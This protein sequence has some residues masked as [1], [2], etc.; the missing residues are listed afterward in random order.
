MST[1]FYP[2][3]MSTYNNRL[4]QG[5]YK[6][7]KGTGP[8]SNPTGIT[9][10][11]IRPLTNNDIGN[12]FTTGFGLPRPI[13]HYRKGIVIPVEKISNPTNNLE[14]SRINDNLNRNVKS[15]YGASLGGGAGGRGLTTQI[16]DAPGSFLVK[17]NPLNETNQSIQS[18]IDCS[19]CKGVSLVANYYPNTTYLTDNPETNTTNP[20]LCCNPERKA[21]RR[22]LPAS[23]NLKKNYYTTLQQYRQNRCQ[24]YEQRVFNF[25]AGLNPELYNDLNNTNE[26][27]TELAIKN[28]KPGSP[29]ALLNTYVANC[30]PNAEL[31]EASEINLI[32]ALVIL[33]VQNGIISAEQAQQIKDLK[34]QTFKEITDYISSL[35]EPQKTA[36]I[37]FYNYFISNPYSGVP[38]TGPS[39]PNGC[40]LVVYK[41]N[42][43][44]F[45]VQGAVSSST[46]ILKL[47]VDTI[48]TNYASF[49]KETKINKLNPGSLPIAPF[50]YKFKV[51][52]CNPGNLIHFQNHKSCSQGQA[53][54][55]QSP[56]PTNHFTQNFSAM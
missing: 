9:S 56:F 26:F 46:R 3:G 30:Q 21:I 25:K 28:A 5:G 43:P 33:M 53:E 37:Q 6:T 29:L 2:L 22:V 15:S 40:K 41:P 1:A 27:I 20:P 12:V 23:T 31:E 10:S 42:N 18:D 19:T 36:A 44:Q 14:I 13:K 50:L 39:N 17:Q 51:E 16:I 34:I 32:N 45:A 35:P 4:P 38:I 55:T 52:K 48:S 54:P 7:W 8:L 49:K 24:T 11:N 47:N